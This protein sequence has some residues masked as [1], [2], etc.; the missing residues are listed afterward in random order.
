MIRPQPQPAVTEQ[1][2]LSA[3]QTPIYFFTSRHDST[4]EHCPE[5]DSP[6]DNLSQRQKHRQNQPYLRPRY[7]AAR[8]SPVTNGNEQRRWRGGASKRQENDGQRR[9][10]SQRQRQA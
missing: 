4:V 1:A 5:A 2:G 9:R 10:Q 3:G 8:R 7:H 6:P